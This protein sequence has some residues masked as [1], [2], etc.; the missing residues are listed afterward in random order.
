MGN[1]DALNRTLFIADNLPILRG[2]DSESVDL[3][4]TDP[5]FNKGVKAFEGIVTAGYDKKGQKVSYKDIWTWRD[6]Q[7]EWVDQITEDHPALKE[8]IEA[9]NTAGGEDMGAFVC[10]LAVRVLE[11]HRVLKPAGSMYLHID[12]TAHAY[13]K[14]MMD[15]VFGRKNF[16]NE[17]VWQ[18]TTGR[19]AANHWGNAHDVLLYYVKTNEASYKPQYTDL[20]ASAM[21]HYRH[22][23]D[24]GVYRV[25]NVNAPERDGGYHYS[26][27]LGERSPRNGYRFPRER[28]L[29]LLEQER[30]IVKQGKVPVLKRYLGESKGTQINTVQTDIPPVVGANK[31][32]RTGY[33]TQKPLALY[34]RIIKASSNEGE[35]VLDPF[36]GCATTCIA[37]ERLGRRWIAIDINKEAEG[38]V[39]DRLVKES[40]LPQGSE[41][42]DRAIRVET[43]PPQRTDDGAEAAPELTLVSPRPKAPRLTARELR[44]RLIM[45]DGM[46]CQGC[47]WVPHHEEYL[48]VDH[49]VPKS[50]EGRDDLRNR[51]LLCSPCNGAKGNK[52][53]LAE[54]RERRIREDRMADKSWDTAWYQRTGRFG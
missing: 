32:Q 46:K 4:A 21:A 54:L 45:E 13:V 29:E 18:R 40:Q 25:D 1:A 33:P 42:W 17:I 20:A 30:L 37:A 6:V 48:E 27:D 19:R 5:P 7:Q 24:V 38:V 15:A 16:R 52:L 35:L 31:S 43:S 22:K 8:V 26:L 47:G 9:A 53:T 50:R 28:A 34:E 3:I 11:M 41:S 36:A 10:W 12:H 14:T 51:V 23:D 2:I 39:L 44:T 49:R